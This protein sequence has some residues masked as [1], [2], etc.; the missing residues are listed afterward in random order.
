MRGAARAGGAAVLPV[1]RLGAWQ[2][3]AGGGLR[4]GGA[5][6]VA[7]IAFVAGGTPA[8]ARDEKGARPRGGG[9][10]GDAG[11]RGGGGGGARAVG[12]SLSGTGGGGGACVPAAPPAGAAAG[13][14]RRIGRLARA[15]RG[16]AAVGDHGAGGRGGARLRVRARPSRRVPRRWRTAVRAFDGFP[17]SEARG[18]GT[19]KTAAH[20]RFPRARPAQAAVWA[21][22]ACHVPAFGQSPLPGG[23]AS[24]AFF[25]RA[26]MEKAAR[27][28]A[29][30][31]LTYFTGPRGGSS[32]F[33][34][35]AG[36]RR[37]GCR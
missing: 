6:A 25:R 15:R 19:A 30:V 9:T 14:K 34:A 29:A 5:A 16:K 33:P 18:G 1:L 31:R 32:S 13:R 20:R 12:K 7:Q 23:G 28:Q 26:G 22:A 2:Y 4:A 17:A 24:D 11:R 27:S 21:S 37:S 3:L 10:L 35:P 8:E 36:R